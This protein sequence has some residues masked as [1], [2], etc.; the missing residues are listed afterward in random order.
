MSQI[1]IENDNIY[2]EESQHLFHNK[3]IWSEWFNF[4]FVNVKYDR[5]VD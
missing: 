4:P 1:Y 3:A 2:A 5:C